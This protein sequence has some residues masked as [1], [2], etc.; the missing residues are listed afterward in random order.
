MI[1]KDARKDRPHLNKFNELCY[2]VKVKQGDYELSDLQTLHDEWVEGITSDIEIKEAEC[3]TPQ[4]DQTTGELLQDQ[5]QLKGVDLQEQ[6]RR[7]QITGE[8][9]LQNMPPLNLY[10]KQ[11]YQQSQKAK[12]RNS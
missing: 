5:K 11:V 3:T 4:V 6:I 8:M 7:D 2:S 1:H 12:E 10:D 9:Q